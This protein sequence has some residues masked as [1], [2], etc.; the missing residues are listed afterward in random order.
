MTTKSGKS[1][2]FQVIIMIDPATGWIEIYAIPA[3]LEDLVAKLV[4]LPWLTRYP[5]P[6]NV[7]VDRGTSS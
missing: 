5:L 6:S 4:E 1:V 3:V 2:Y 7:M